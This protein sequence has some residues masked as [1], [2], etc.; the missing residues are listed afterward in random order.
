MASRVGNPKRLLDWLTGHCSGS[1]TTVT[2]TGGTA[3]ADV[4]LDYT[5]NLENAA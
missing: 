1:K 3:Q 5:G 2:K 4:L